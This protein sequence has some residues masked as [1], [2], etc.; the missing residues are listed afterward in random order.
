MN[1]CCNRV[2]RNRN[3]L[4]FRSFFWFLLLPLALS[5]AVKYMMTCQ[6]LWPSRVCETPHFQT[7]THPKIF[8]KKFLEV[9]LLSIPFIIISSTGDC[10]IVFWVEGS[11]NRSSNKHEMQEHRRWDRDNQDLIESHALLCSWNYAIRRKTN[12]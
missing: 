1:E 3:S 11:C 7:Y 10:R 2:A 4:Y 9:F 8:T 6:W 5:S 12:C